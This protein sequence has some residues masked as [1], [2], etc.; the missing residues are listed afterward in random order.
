[1]KLGIIVEDKTDGE[2]FEVLIRRI[3]P[4]IT[5]TPIRGG[6][7]C[8]RMERKA[9]SWMR[10]LSVSG[11]KAIVLVRDLDRNPLNHCLNDEDH[12]RTRLN[13]IEI[14]PSIDR[15]ICIPIE[16]L[17]AWFFSDPVVLAY[18]SRANSQPNHKGFSSP[19][20]IMKPKEKLIAMSRAGNAKPLYSTNDNKDLAERLDLDL[21]SSR[22]PSFRDF[23][24]WV[25]RQS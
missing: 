20:L 11:C 1:M 14:P 10:E 8:S 18:V 13:E 7:G 21:C 4:S 3:N 16:E 25:T 23:R 2:A 19:H 22:C 17:E 5:K 24:Q 9:K 6:N 12:M 15:H